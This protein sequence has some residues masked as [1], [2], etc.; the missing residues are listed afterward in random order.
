MPT[1]LVQPLLFV[2]VIQTQVDLTAGGGAATF[3]G[4]CGI[5]FLTA[6]TATS[7]GMQTHWSATSFRPAR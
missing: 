7:Y 5:L 3:F 1:A 2:S 6:L 4:I